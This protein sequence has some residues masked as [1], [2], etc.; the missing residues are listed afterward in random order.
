MPARAKSRRNF[1]F[2]TTQYS[3]ALGGTYK[4][5]RERKKRLVEQRRDRILDKKLR[6]QELAAEAKLKAAEKKI[7]AVEKV[8]DRKIEKAEAKIETAEKK[9][10]K[11]ALTESG[12]AAIEARMKREIE[13]QE[14]Y[15]QAAIAKYGNPSFGY[16]VYQPGFLGE[17]Q[18]AH[19]SSKPAAE[20]WARSH[21]IQG[22][23]IKRAFAKNPAVSAAQYRLAQSVLSGTARESTMPRSVAQEIVDRTPARLRSIYMM[24]SAGGSANPDNPAS[25]RGR[26]VSDLEKF[27][28]NA[29]VRVY[30]DDWLVR[31]RG[32]R[33]V[34]AID[35][36]L[37]LA[38]RRESHNPGGSGHQ[39]GARSS[40]LR[41]PEQ[42]SDGSEEYKQASRTAELFHGRPVKE[43]IEVKETIKTHDWYVS[44]GP[45]V[46]LVIKPVTKKPKKKVPLPFHQTAEGTVQLFCSPDGR[47]FYL[48][49]GDQE[50]DLE[51]FGM[52][53]GTRWF[54]DHMLIGEAVEITYRDR[55]AFHRFNLTDY[56][57]KLGEETGDKPE[58]IYDS[59]SQK[60]GIV[61]GAYHVE[62]DDL[63]DGMSPGIVN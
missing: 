33:E 48:R 1:T 37:K 50:L 40:S 5:D 46:K 34:E 3:A 56:F 31:D 47:Q 22:Y 32:R 27:R 30:D 57:H 2:G 8:A 54:R 6:A 29:M 23:K 9:V 38:R 24:G 12:F 20:T 21:D 42:Q 15:K 7:A 59:L 45:L 55:K 13:A 44:I 41:N 58:L 63:V 18:L 25:Y 62:M 39:P 35:H 60:L 11:G 49:G 51:A 36:A 10:S 14:K 53:E 16:G 26:S 4:T 17:T 28:V 61:G 43:E 52:G 19:F